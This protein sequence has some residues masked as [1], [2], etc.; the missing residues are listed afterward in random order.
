MSLH[1]RPVGSG[2]RLAILAAVVMLVGCLLPWF[3]FVGDAG[4][5][6][7]GALDGSGIL[8]FIAALAV[9]AIVTLPYAAG[10]RPIGAD[11]WLAYALVFLVALVGLFVWPVQFLDAPAGLLPDRA[12]GY[13]VAFIGSL[14]LARAAF[15]IAREPAR[16]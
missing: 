6:P 3:K 5:R 8:V 13:W 16:P 15:N 9:L 14:I 2:R 4:E 1:R 7:Y 12:P 10:D 11:R